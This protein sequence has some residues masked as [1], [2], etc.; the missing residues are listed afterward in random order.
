MPVVDGVFGFDFKK[1]LC[2]RLHG[3]LLTALSKKNPMSDLLI[4]LVI[5]K[6]ILPFITWTSLWKMR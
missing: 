1:T 2:R 5:Y 4:G 3:K 6:L